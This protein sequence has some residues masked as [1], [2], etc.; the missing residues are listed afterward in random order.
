MTLQH[1][2]SAL[3]T[4]SASLMCYIGF[5]I[6]RGKDVPSLLIFILLT[7]LYINFFAMVK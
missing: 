7:G 5:L 4:L 6:L 1:A 2:L 3:L